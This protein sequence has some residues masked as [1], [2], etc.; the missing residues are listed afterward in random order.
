MAIA[1]QPWSHPIAAAPTAAALS[2]ALRPLFARHVSAPIWC[3]PVDIGHGE[4]VEVAGVVEAAC[5]HGFVLAWRGPGGRR[6]AFIAW[7]DLW[8]SQGRVQVRGGPL[9]GPVAA[10]LAAIPRPLAAG[11]RP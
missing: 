2:R 1:S 7:T 4:P 5:A 6:T 10:A 11:A 9:A 3:G 8:A